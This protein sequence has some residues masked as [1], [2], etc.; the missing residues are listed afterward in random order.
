M[1][2]IPTIQR[3]ETRLG[4]LQPAAAVIPRTPRAVYVNPE[5]FTRNAALIAGVAGQ[6]AR[7]LADAAQTLAEVE[8]RQK[9][10]EELTWVMKADS[11]LTDAWTG[12]LPSELEKQG[13]DTYGN[14]ARARKWIDEQAAGWM[15]SAPSEEARLTLGERV[16]TL[17]RNGVMQLAR[18]QA[19][20]RR[21]V[22]ERGFGTSLDA[23]RKA[24]YLGQADPA[25]AVGQMSG[26]YAAAARDEVRLFDQGTAEALAMDAS[27]RIYGAYLD[28]LLDRDPLRA[29]QEFNAGHFN[30]FLSA[31]QLNAYADRIAAKTRE[32]ERDAEYATKEAQLARKRRVRELQDLMTSDLQKRFDTGEGL[33]GVDIERSLKRLKNE[34]LEQDLKADTYELDQIIEGYA[35]RREINMEAHHALRMI[36]GMPLDERAAFL[37]QYKP[38]DRNYDLEKKRYQVIEA[39]V[40]DDTQALAQDPA[41]YF[42]PEIQRHV[43]QLVTRGAVDR[44][45]QA[46]VGRERVKESL[47]LQTEA[48]LPGIAQR[49]LSKIETQ[50]W[51]AR[52][53]EAGGDERASMLRGLKG[54]RENQHKVLGEL[55][56]S[57]GHALISLLPPEA[58]GP[59]ARAIEM[60]ETEFG[61]LPDDKKDLEQKSRDRF[62]KDSEMGG[63]LEELA[64][65]TGNPQYLA[66]AKSFEDL[67][68][69]MAWLYGDDDDGAE[70]LWKPFDFINDDDIGY[71]WIPKGQ[72]KGR[73]ID[74][75]N[76]VRRDRIE[77]DLKWTRKYYADEKAYQDALDDLVENAFWAPASDG[78]GYVLH[79]HKT[80]KM[81]IDKDGRA[82]RTHVRSLAGG[83]AF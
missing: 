49:A 63:V 82:I 30:P 44:E 8:R 15:D 5:D 71:L 12:F 58:A 3:R 64:R 20:Q 73:W 48:G 14:V 67:N 65:A 13:E 36:H 79:D 34:W 76:E 4:R 60:K 33:A 28:G 40:Q 9:A 45:D 35:E 10:Q 26:E 51:Q 70:T 72:D 2:N 18:L 17:T 56:L 66:Q 75:L 39:A 42:A 74:F 80:G 27:N 22:A 32:L 25:V 83:G 54:F 24:V 57:Y 81:L 19:R 50:A 55:D 62:Y 53:N 11:S 31:D 21:N 38:T 37:K 59:A 29:I 43:D 68:T 1:P 23:K 77:N 69:R 7:N 52:F 46:A 47:R 6:T 61:L 41:A 16:Q 78:E